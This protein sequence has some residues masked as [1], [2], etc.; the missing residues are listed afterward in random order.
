MNTNL[1]NKS[2]MLFIAAPINL[3]MLLW[4]S[5]LIYSGYVN[6]QS[7]NKDNSDQKLGKNSIIQGLLIL[8]TLILCNYYI[9]K[10]IK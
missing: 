6:Y 7:I 2:S 9:I 4:G 8:I 3:F 10:K 5:I 1:I